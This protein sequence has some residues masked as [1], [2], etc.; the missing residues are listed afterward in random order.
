MIATRIL[1]APAMLL[2]VGM[3]S[4]GTLLSNLFSLLTDGGYFI[5]E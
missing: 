2:L 3:M 4:M 1:S 5:P